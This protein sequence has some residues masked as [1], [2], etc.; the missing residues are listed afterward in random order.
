MLRGRRSCEVAP[1]LA[2]SLLATA[3]GCG[4]SRVDRVRSAQ[5][6]VSKEQE[7]DKLVT[8][9]KVFAQLGDHTRAAQYFAQAL[10]AGADPPQVLPLLMRSYV[11]TNRYR[12]AIELGERYVQKAPREHR[13]RFLLSTLYLAIKEPSRARG[14][15]DAVLREDPE[16][17]EAHYVM[18]VLLRDHEADWEG[19]D[20]HFRE[21]LRLA[22]SGPHAEEAKGSL[23]KTVP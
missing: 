2:V 1:L 20:R 19:A 22:P 9:G 8:R 14:H 10:D 18:A 13:L 12:H 17:S 23:L 4:S 3:V 6:T 15:L 16:N 21:Y 11:V 5:E 7:P